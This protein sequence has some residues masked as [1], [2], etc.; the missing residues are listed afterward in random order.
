[1]MKKTV[2]VFF[3][4]F[5]L[6]AFTLPVHA[7]NA[8]QLI[9]VNKATNKLAY[10]NGGKLVKTFK[11]ATGRQRSYTP[12]GKFMIVRKI[13][14]RP[15]Y[16]GNIPG[17]DPRNP[18][19]NRWLGLNARGTYGTTYAIHGNNNPSSIGTYASSGCIRMYDNEVEWLY[20]QVRLY[21]PVI[22]TYSSKS[23]ESLAASNNY[24]VE[25]KISTF[26]AS[27]N[28]PQEENT[29]INVKAEISSGYL[30][31]YKFSVYSGDKWTTIKNYSTSNNVNWKPAKYGNYKVKVQVKSRNSRKGFDDEK[32]VSYQVFKPAIV[33]SITTDKASP[34][35]SN[36]SITIEAG[37][38]KNVDNHFKYLIYDGNKWVT[39]KN[40]STS[41]SV[42]WT[43]KK[44]GD[45]KI[46]VQAR[47]KWSKKPYDHEKTISYKVYEKAAIKGVTASGT[48]LH[49]D[50][51]IMA[52]AKSNK[53]SDNLFQYSLVTG[54][55]ETVIQKYSSNPN[56][57][58]KTSNT[59]AYKIRVKVKNKLSKAQWE[60][61]KDID[62]RFYK[63]EVVAP[64]EEM[65]GL[66]T[67]VEMR[68]KVTGLDHPVYQFEVYKDS[69]SKQKQAFSA[70][71]ILTWIPTEAGRYKVKVT[72]KEKNKVIDSI[73]KNYIAE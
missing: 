2:T 28:S 8:S 61:F 20:S 40:Y 45:Y 47:H 7:E 49:V 72:V 30:P 73:E 54:T 58:W 17:G 63:L 66:N 21:T 69:T 9:I 39:L 51:G 60:D 65:L 57:N 55:K 67:E 10:M 18:L 25:S 11:V 23:F 62:V 13:I 14:N 36:T 42:K 68:A 31:L 46:K 70:A 48:I 35:P 64:A 50:K 33:T 26:T 6:L 43:P 22:I 24:V 3:L 29:V 34:Q 1:M 41:T 53:D 4:I 37:S 15:Y 56:L 38:N 52:V 59:G 19:G 27:K 16:H 32:T 71:D 12:E 44:I 5:S